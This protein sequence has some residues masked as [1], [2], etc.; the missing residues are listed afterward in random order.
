MRA[1]PF[2]MFVDGAW[3]AAAERPTYPIPNPATEETVAHAPEATRGDVGRA[4]AAAR[5]AF[6]HGP[7]PRTKP[8]ERAA[9]L[10]KIAD[11]IQA[12]KEEFRELLVSA[13]AACAMTHVLQLETPI[14]ALYN[15]AELVASF[16]WEEEVPTLMV[17]TKRG[18]METHA[19]VVRQP[20]G[21]CALIPTWN[22]PLFTTINKIAPAIAAGCTMVVKPSPWGPLVDLLLA[23]VIAECDLPPGVFNVV[24]GQAPELG[25]DLVESPQVDKVSFTGS[26]ATGKKIMRA[27]A[28]T[29]KRV[30]LELGGKSA[31]VI[32]DDANVETAAPS[33]ASPAFFHAGQGCALMTRVLVPKKMHDSLVAATVAFIE[34]KVKLGDP[35][36][37]TVNLGPVIRDERRQAI[38]AMIAAGREQGAILATGGGR[39]PGFERGYFVEP[40]V[41]ANVRNHMTIAR[42]EIFGPVVSILPYQDDDEAVRIANA[43]E[44]GLYGGIVT[45]DVERA[46]SVARRIRTGGVGINNATNLLHAPFGGFKQSGIGREGGVFGMHE[47]TELQTIAWNVMQ[48]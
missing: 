44:M 23:E 16:P 19:A 21:V 28:D 2:R 9:I 4:I 47:F 48:S 25:A 31:L 40:T 24:T 27:A 35:A 46:K 32:L 13:H 18:M 14:Y 10:T 26:V 39:P 37:P 8:A 38:E 45:N 33:A 41:F 11:G 42:E 5:R 34:R 36:D 30:H 15:H 1:Q 29:L 20:A 3:I 12:R 6:D 17:P 7:W 22:F 43:S